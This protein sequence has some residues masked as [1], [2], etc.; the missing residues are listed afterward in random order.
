MTTS[1]ITCQ[2]TNTTAPQIL[3][4]RS[5][6]RHFRAIAPDLDFWYQTD[7]LFSQLIPPFYKSRWPWR[8]REGRLLRA[9]VNDTK[10]VNALGKRKMEWKFETAETLEII[11]KRIPLFREN[12]RTIEL[13][14]TR[15]SEGSRALRYAM[16]ILAS[17]CTR[18]TKLVI[19]CWAGP[20]DLTEIASSCPFLETLTCSNPD[21]NFFGSLERLN[22]LKTLHMDAREFEAIGPWLPLQS[23]ETLTELRLTCPRVDISFFDIPS[24]ETFTNLTSLT[25]GPLNPAL[26]KH[27]QHSPMTLETFKMEV[28]F[29][30]APIEIVRSVLQSPCLTNLKEFGSSTIH[31]EFECEDPPTT[32]DSALELYIE[33][34]W[35]LVF[36]AF[37]PILR[38]VERVHLNVPLQ[39]DCCTYFARMKEI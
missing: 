10:F 7:F 11:S 17:R 5:V 16:Y 15:Y 2:T 29:Q 6:C 18:I 19:H 4:L 14:L 20:V 27:L 30:F 25:I 9:L 1:S 23:T 24:L 13:G 3:V 26:V 22:C 35:S 36:D 34:Y 38:S 21:A 12:A 33:D 39:V 28:R 32:Q 31:K 8:T 37:T